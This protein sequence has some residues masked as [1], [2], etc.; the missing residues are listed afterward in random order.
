[1]SLFESVVVLGAGGHGREVAEIHAHAFAHGGPALAGFLDDDEARWGTEI[2]G[3]PVIGGWVWL[4]QQDPSRLGVTV[5]VGR[6]PVT[7]A[8]AARVRASGFRLAQAVSPRAHVSPLAEVAS[9][10]I[11]FPHVSVHMRA[12][13]GEAVTLNVGASVSHDS[14]VGAASNV[15]PGARLAGSVTVGERAYIGM[16]AA[17]I[18][19]ITIGAD[20]VVGAGAVVLHDIP[21]GATAVGVPARIVRTTP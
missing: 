5:A 16:M 15:N 10:A 11:L 18:Q 2:D 12:I 9:G 8:L 13:I 6:P 7:A 20:A 21:A 19:G 1:M 3:V 4:A 14:V 17:G